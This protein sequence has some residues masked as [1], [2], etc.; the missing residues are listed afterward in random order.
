MKIPKRRLAQILPTDWLTRSTQQANHHRGPQRRGDCGG[1][2]PKYE[3][4][5]GQRQACASVGYFRAKGAGQIPQPNSARCY[6]GSPKPLGSWSHILQPLLFLKS[7]KAQTGATSCKPQP[8][9][10][11][12][13]NGPTL[14]T[15]LY[16]QLD[17]SLV[18]HVATAF[19]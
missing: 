19:G 5:S 4:R 10:L 9:L 13:L 18:R 1:R 3:V 14:W 17:R 15:C 6:M 12:S 7:S 8:Q 16:V 2:S 11:S